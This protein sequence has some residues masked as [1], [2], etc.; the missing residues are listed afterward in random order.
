LEDHLVL[1]I[2]IRIKLREGRLPQH[3]IPRVW[4]GPGNGETCDG[5]DKIVAK[6]QVSIEAGSVCFHVWCF[7]LW[8]A[9]RRA[10]EDMQAGAP[11]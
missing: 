5:C 6:A 10:A 2:L 3:S 7:Y 1:R 8:D 11:E 9:E 4:G